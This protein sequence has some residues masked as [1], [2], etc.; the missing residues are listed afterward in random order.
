MVKTAAMPPANHSHVT[1]TSRQIEYLSAPAAVSMADQW[2]E[3]A[4]LDHFWI[5]RRFDVLQ[6]LAGSLIRGAREIVDIGCGNGL[7]QRQIEEAFGREVTGFDLNEFALKQNLSRISKVCCYDI[8][9]QDAALQ[10]RFDV[11]FLFDVLEHIT[12]EDRFFK[13]LLFHLA[14]GGKVVVNV[15]AGNWAFSV[16]DEAAG[17]VRRYSFETLRVAAGRNAIEMTDWSYWGLP[18]VPALALR[19]LW[20]MGKHD[21]KKIISAGFGSRTPAINRMLGFLS[22]WEPIPQTFLGTSLMAVL[23]AGRGS[24]WRGN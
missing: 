2:F 8:Y 5:R 11:I 24:R 23:Q 17:H 6:R 1:T 19:K 20:L 12:D 13:A 21:Q 16:Y 7:L 14:P 10:G 18:L 3:I 15:P 22:L 4:A 9:Q